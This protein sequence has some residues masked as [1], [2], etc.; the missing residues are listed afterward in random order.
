VEIKNFK[1]MQKG[2]LSAF[3]DIYFPKIQWT[4]RGF[5]Y[6]VSGSKRWVSMPSRSYQDD[7]G[8]TCYSEILSMP[9]EMKAKFSEEALKVIDEYLTKENTTCMNL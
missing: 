4:V 6:F 7:N 3:V 8:K 9:K 1:S 2:S 5:Q